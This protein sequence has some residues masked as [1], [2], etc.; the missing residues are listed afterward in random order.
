MAWKYVIVRAG[1]QEVPFIFPEN[2]VHAGMAEAVKIYFTSVAQ[3][4]AGGQLTEAALD[5]IAASIEP[6]AAGEVNVDFGKPSGR[7]STLGLGP[8]ENDQ[9]FLQAF[10]YHHGYV[11]GPDP[12]EEALQA[13]R[14]AAERGETPR[15]FDS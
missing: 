4:M 1:N 2:I 11:E 8:R 13:M 3:V 9:N 7:S 5:A 14:E 12:T 6:V 10:P 15:K